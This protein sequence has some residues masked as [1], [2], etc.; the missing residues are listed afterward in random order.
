[1]SQF[2]LT[3]EDYNAVIRQRAKNLGR[4]M[5]CFGRNIQPDESHCPDERPA[6]DVVELV[7]KA[8]EFFQAMQE[9]YALALEREGLA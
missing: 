9:I 3:R 7:S 5:Q 4:Q 1:M 8:G 2:K 6:A